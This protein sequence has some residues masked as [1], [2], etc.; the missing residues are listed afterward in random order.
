[1]ADTGAAH[2]ASTNPVV[3][4]FMYRTNDGFGTFTANDVRLR[5]NYADNG[6][7][8]GDVIEIRVL[9]IEMVY[10]P[11]GAFYAG[12][13][14][15]SPNAFRE[16]STGDN[17]PWYISSEAA[18]ATTAATTGNYYY[19]GGLGG[20]AA[21]S[22]FTIPAAFPKG[23]GPFYMMK[24][25]ISQGQ[26]IA[27]FNTLTSTQ[28]AERDITG[29]HNS[30][31]GKNTD[32]I[33]MRNNI[34][35]TGSGEATLNGGTHSGVAMNFMSWADLTALLDWSGLRPM[36][37]LEYEKSGRGSRGPTS[38]IA[39]V[40]GEYAWGNSTATGATSITNDGSS[41]ERGQV[42]SNITCGNGAA[43]QGPLRVGNF[44]MGVT[45]RVASGAGFYGVMELSGNLYEIAVTVGSSTGRAF[46]G[47]YHGDGVLAS[48][49]GHNVTSWPGSGGFGL[50]G[51]SWNYACTASYLSSRVFGAASFPNREDYI[52][53]RGVR[54]VSVDNTPNALNWNDADASGSCTATT[55][56]QTIAGISSSITLELSED[57]SG[58]TLQYSLNGGA[59]TSF[60]TLPAT[61][62]VSNND[63]LA[64]RSSSGVGRTRIFTVK[65]VTDG[66]V[67]LDA[68]TLIVS[69]S[70]G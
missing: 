64:F 41:S 61:L 44:A 55:N 26:Y 14:A 15:T 67:V 54:S 13:N 47:R 5:W 24:G 10:I 39:A 23:Y 48:G 30:F 33:S 31:R 57:S 4:I 56:S 65:N 7:S 3:G 38:P 11:D 35:W 1:L 53:G 59:W 28:K 34:S 63:T 19:P 70:A 12:D 50:R 42:G 2:N 25:E 51:A 62:S 46:E 20:D 66:N 45:S 18:I 36:S 9:A 49:G 43:V 40:S 29:N 58:L 60:G 6:A 52:G 22:V 21:D 8:S 37:E 32:S 69:C 68:F 17:D 16:K 27:F